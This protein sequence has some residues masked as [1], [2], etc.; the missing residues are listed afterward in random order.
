MNLHINAKAD[1][2]QSELKLKHDLDLVRVVSS[3]HQKQHNETFV[4]RWIKQCGLK[5]SEVF[6]NFRSK[7]NWWKKPPKL[8]FKS[9]KANTIVCLVIKAVMEPSSWCWWLFWC[10]CSKKKRANCQIVFPQHRQKTWNSPC[11]SSSHSEKTLEVKKSFEGKKT[12]V[13]TEKN[14]SRW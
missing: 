9:I 8:V 11:V 10:R 4:L 7:F 3:N 1:V 13:T 5:K 2:G 12:I 6:R 14:N